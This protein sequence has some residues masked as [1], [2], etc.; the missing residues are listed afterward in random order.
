M[1]WDKTKPDSTTKIREEPALI[2]DNWEAIEENDSGVAAS[3]LNQWVVHL[4]DRSTIGGSNTPARIDNIGL[5]YCR[6]DGSNNEFYFEDSQNPANEIQM[7]AD[8]KMGSATTEMVAQDIAFG[9]VSTAYAA[10]NVITAYGRFNSST[11]TVL[12]QFGCTIGAVGGSSTTITFSTAR[13]T[14]NYIAVATNS[15][16][17]FGAKVAVSAQNLTDFVLTYDT[18]V[19]NFMVCGAL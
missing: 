2:T 7:T 1:A 12:D 19:I 9:S 18:G 13:S 16:T 5:L 4:I 6:N 11:A 17:A 10:P 8:G 14:T 15:N 3:S